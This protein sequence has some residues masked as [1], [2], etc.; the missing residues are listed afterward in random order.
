MMK[1]LRCPDEAE[2]WHLPQRKIKNDKSVTNTRLFTPV[3]GFL[4]SILSADPNAPTS[5][6]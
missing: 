1:V 2:G 5:A 4:A 3:I 6:W